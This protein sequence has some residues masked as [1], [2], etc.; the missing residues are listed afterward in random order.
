M[1]LLPLLIVVVFFMIVAAGILW[2]VLRAIRKEAEVMPRQA[3]LAPPREEALRA[4]GKLEQGMGGMESR[5]VAL[6]VTEIIKRYLERQ[7]Q[8]D[9]KSHTTDEYYTAVS[10]GSARVPYELAQG[11]ADLFTY[12]DALKFQ[13]PEESEAHKQQIM[14][15]AVYIVQAEV[16][17][18]P[19]NPV[20]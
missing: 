8:V 2:V 15:Q 4:L 1:S 14:E 6:N 13:A 3:P 9:L 17:P 7:Y 10:Q 18:H 5:E 20:G 11:L 16:Q 19:E 12:C